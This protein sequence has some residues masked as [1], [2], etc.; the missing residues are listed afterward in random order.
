ME[1]LYLIGGL[2][3][4]ILGIVTGLYASSQIEKDID[5]RTTRK[6]LINKMNDWRH[7]K[8]QK[9]EKKKTK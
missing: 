1:G 9:N 2:V 6:N 5:T 4:Y 7:E 8:L 3:L